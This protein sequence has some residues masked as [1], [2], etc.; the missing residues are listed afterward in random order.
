[1]HQTPMTMGRSVLLNLAVRGQSPTDMVA[2][3]ALIEDD[4]T[5]WPLR[6]YLEE[7]GVIP[8]K[9]LTVGKPYYVETVTKYY[10]GELVDSDF[11]GVTLV[12]AAWIPDTGRFHEAFLNGSFNEVE[13]L[14][15]NLRLFLPAGVI[16][17]IV[18]WPF[19]IPREVK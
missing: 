10:V 1:M 6:D 16:S 18:E 4:W 9:N 8:M 12:K 15:D 5:E 2:R 11:S 13:P 17:G 19:P 3:G 14:P 7:Q